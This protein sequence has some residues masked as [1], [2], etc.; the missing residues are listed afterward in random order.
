MAIG[1]SAHWGLL[2]QD[3]SWLDLI[4]SDLAWMWQQLHNTCSLGDSYEH[5]ARWLEVI[6]HHRGYWRRLLKRAKVH[7]I[8]VHARE[9]SCLEAHMRL[10]EML[11]Q[12]KILPQRT[13]QVHL[14][15]PPSP[16]GCM[17]C[18]LKCRSHAGEAAHMNR[19]H[20]LVHPVR[21][22]FDGTQCSCCLKEYHTTGKL[23]MHLIRSTHCRQQ[24]IGRR[25]WQQP[26]PGIGSSTDTRRHEA[27]D[28][29]LPPLRAEGPCLPAVPPRD[30]DPTDSS[31]YEDLALIINC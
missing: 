2:N 6:Q 29:R 19:R 11:Y 31:L 28:G 5:T 24:L 27:L 20:N 8:M 9:Q 14:S 1:S 3:H 18:Q 13:Y 22:L 4:R 23:K 21:R 26:Q 12:Y 16:F 15:E 30:L 25:H 17:L 7:S 10:R